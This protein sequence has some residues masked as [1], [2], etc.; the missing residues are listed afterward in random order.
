[1]VLHLIS[2]SVFC[3]D[4]KLKTSLFV[5][6]FRAP[7]YGPSP[8]LSHHRLYGEMQEEARNTPYPPPFYSTYPQRE[9]I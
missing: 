2:P 6:H 4:V 3:S 7:A 8:P 5:V 1:M 9:V